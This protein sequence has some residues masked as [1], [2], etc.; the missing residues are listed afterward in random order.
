MK[1][2]SKRYLEVSKE[3]AEQ[4]K[5]KEKEVL[6]Q[7]LDREKEE[8]PQIEGGEVYDA[9]RINICDFVHVPL[10]KEGVFTWF[11]GAQYPFKGYIYPSAV[12]AVHNVKRILRMQIE[13]ALYPP[14]VITLGIISCIP[15]LK[16]KFLSFFA[17][18]FIFTAN[19]V[20]E[21]YYIFP[22]R[23]CRVG[24]ELHRAG[25]AFAS[26]LNLSEFVPRHNFPTFFKILCMIFEYDNSYRYRGQD[27]LG[28]FNRKNLGD[29][30]MREILRVWDLGIERELDENTKCKRKM[31]KKMIWL[32]LFFY[33][34]IKNKIAEFLL[35][36]NFEEAK[37]DEGDLYDCA[38][39]SGYDFGGM[40]L[41]KRIE[42]RFKQ[43]YRR[44]RKTITGMLTHKIQKFNV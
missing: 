31:F 35:I 28:E 15:F 13:L 26:G 25:A 14:M 12:N 16:Y 24:R 3:I 30:P 22:Y 44:K 23:F 7:I 37:L 34:Q 21:Q 11:R 29:N 17:E 10:Y 32:L 33:P 43:E 4:D 41:D 38:H 9:R 39:R 2:E 36:M 40:N 42:N 27:L 5:D 19:T 1:D 18:R 8:Q 20:L 6:T